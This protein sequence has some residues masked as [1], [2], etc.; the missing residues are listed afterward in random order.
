MRS[1]AVPPM[2]AVVIHGVTDP[3]RPDEADTLDQ[4]REVGDSL[5]RL[6][7]VTET[8]ALSLDLSALSSLAA[9]PPAL[10]FNLVEALDGDGRLI[11]LAPTVLEH[12]G[13]SFTGCPASAIALTTDKLLA[14][15]VLE[16][17]GLS[18][19]ETVAA[20][21]P[22]ATPDARYIVKSLT[23]DA[24]YGIDAGSVVSGDQV[25][26]E[27]AERAAR[28]GGTWFA[29]RYIEG[30]EV[31]VSV[32]EAAD[33]SPRVLPIAEI[34][35]DGYGESRP[36]IV[37]YEAKWAVGSFAYT[38]T[39]RRF[40]DPAIEAVLVGELTRLAAKAWDA[41]RLAG[42][43]RVDFRIDNEGRP[44][45]LEVN[46]NPCI[47]RDA[48]LVAAAEV[49]GFGYDDLVGCIVSAAR[50]RCARASAT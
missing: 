37:D 4:V 12:L 9:E 39:P 49:A 10:V 45:I 11:H 19:P 5:R 13:L 22:E 44:F 31:N 50:R 17:S 1:P 38:H 2:R 8:L 36:R 33:G 14:K 25:A 43:A 16:A 7:Y 23:E 15:T 28:F 27:V 41:L 42:Y 30:R 29:E 18:V 26:P 32:I 21:H 47:A 20:S 35:F 48:G 3:T 6:G 24:S 46:A 40:L 34:I